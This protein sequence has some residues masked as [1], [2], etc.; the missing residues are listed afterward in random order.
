MTK[1]MNILSASAVLLVTA[2]GSNLKELSVEEK[3]RFQ[4]TLATIG[5]STSALTALASKQPGS[6]TSD[7]TTRVFESMAAGTSPS[8][9]SQEM[10]RQLERAVASKE[11]EIVSTMPKNVGSGKSVKLKDAR[12]IVK[13]VTCPISVDLKMTADGTE[14]E[15]S[16]KFNLR[17]EIKEAQFKKL[18]QIDSV[19]IQGSINF[20]ANIPTDAQGEMSM[21]MNVDL[22]G[23]FH[24]DAEKDFKTYLRGNYTMNGNAKQN[25][26]SGGAE[27]ALGVEFKDF[28]G[29]LKTVASINTSA[30]KIESKYFVNRKEITETEMQEWMKATN[31][32]SLPGLVPTR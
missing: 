9:E 13:G 26:I 14:K 31:L 27:F 5:N 4:S 11:C 25:R 1:F 7:I 29:E 12:F 3:E 30:G 28:T 17:Y 10:A 2:C 19:E 22:N 21:R 24:S 6:E 15:G 32:P 20:A 18:A 16:A 8:R 23:N